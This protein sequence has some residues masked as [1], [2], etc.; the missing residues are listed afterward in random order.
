MLSLVEVRTAQGTLLSLPLDD[1]SSGIIVE[2]I[3]G[4]EPVKATFGT[5]SFASMDGVQ[6]QSSRREARP[7]TIKLKLE[8]DYI[9][10]SVRD[11]RTMLY[12]YFMPKTAVSL[13]FYTTD[14]LTVDISGRVEDFQAPLF[15]QE[16]KVTIP[17]LCFDPDLVAIEPTV[18]SG[19]TVEDDTETLIHYDGNIETGFS[20]V[21]NV[22][23]AESAFTIY[24]RRPDNSMQILDFSGALGI[25]NT[26]TI[27]TVD[28]AKSVKRASS[29]ASI[30]MLYAIS[31]QSNWIQLFPGDNFFRVYATGTPIPYELTYTTR[32]GGL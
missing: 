11:L 5:S 19:A 14:G 30:S 20:F 28:R 8:P 7:L 21:L 17:I 10:K 1:A 26:L 31:S 22:N 18:I 32:Y 23:R 6:Y 4:L 27:S 16:P 25:G 9:T 12:D 15:V 2:D 13:R 24:N 29:G 3:E